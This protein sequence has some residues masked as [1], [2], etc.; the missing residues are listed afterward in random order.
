MQTMPQ[1]KGL[2]QG[3]YENRTLF[4]K[5]LSMLFP[6]SL[7]YSTLLEK[8]KDSSCSVLTDLIPGLENSHPTSFHS[9]PVLA[10]LV[11]L[12][13]PLPQRCFPITLRGPSLSRSLAHFHHRPDCNLQLHSSNSLH[14][15]E[16]FKPAG[17]W[18]ALALDR[19]AGTE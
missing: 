6:C 15:K 4:Y 7:G 18:A 8:N 1:N 16:S 19:V 2:W 9:C 11:L 14:S 13:M 5:A 10:M 12:E 17:G 3:R